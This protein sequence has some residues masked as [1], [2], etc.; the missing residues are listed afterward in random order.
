MSGLSSSSR[1]Q[2]VQVDLLADDAPVVGRITRI[3][4]SRCSKCHRAEFPRRETCPSCLQP[5]MDVELGPY[6]KIKAATSVEHQ[7]PDALLDAPY[8]VIAAAFVEG[9][10]VLG[11]LVDELCLDDFRI[12]DEVEVVVTLIGENL[13]YGFRLVCPT[14]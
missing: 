12:G 11:V 7:P 6:A 10:S 9:I 3:A 5:M 14:A 4:G 8:V 13:G 1:G 2:G